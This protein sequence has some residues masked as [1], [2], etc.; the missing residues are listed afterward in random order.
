[1]HPPK[2]KKKPTRTQKQ[3]PQKTKNEVKT[4][5]GHGDSRLEFRQ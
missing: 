4:K 3:T 5:A 1:M 2:F